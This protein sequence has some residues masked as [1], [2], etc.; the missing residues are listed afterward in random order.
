MQLQSKQ[1]K[2]T[3][4]VI[5]LVNRVMLVHLYNNGPTKVNERTLKCR[6]AFSLDLTYLIQIRKIVAQKLVKVEV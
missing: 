1:I 2:E 4:F 6:Q 5:S 3:V